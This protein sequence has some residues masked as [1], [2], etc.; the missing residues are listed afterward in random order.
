[1]RVA[2]AARLNAALGRAADT[3]IGRPQ[4][5]VAPMPL[6]SLDTLRAW[7]EASRPMLG[8]SRAAVARAGAEVDLARRELWPDLSIGAG[9]GQRA[10]DMGT[11]RMGSLMIGFSL[12]VF[13]GARQ[14]RMRD[15]AS[16]ME[17]MAEAELALDRALVDAG[18]AEL[19]AELERSRSLIA[20]YRQEILPQADGNVVSAMSSYR[21]GAVDF[22]TLVDARMSANDYEQELHALRAEYGQGIAELE[23]TIG[24]ELT[25]PGVMTAET[26]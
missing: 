14:L 7:A 18:I 12:P 17:S 13:A 1:M 15:E 3:P 10:G 24:R 4:P 25:R 2:S 20:L 22:M 21:S 5:P 16:A 23:M 9:Y 11:E 26:P 6:P 19:L 8:R